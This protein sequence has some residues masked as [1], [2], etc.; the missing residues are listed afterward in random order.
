MTEALLTKAVFSALLGVI[1]LVIIWKKGG[2][3]DG[4]SS[5]TDVSR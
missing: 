1:V 2:P 5:N 4:T 3:A